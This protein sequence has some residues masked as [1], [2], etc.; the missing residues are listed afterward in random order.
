[1]LV[2]QRFNEEE[3]ILADLSEKIEEYFSY[4]WAN[5]KNQAIECLSEVELLEQLPANV[6][7]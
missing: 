5:N 7:H 2:L 3:P 6:Q 4:R 1:L